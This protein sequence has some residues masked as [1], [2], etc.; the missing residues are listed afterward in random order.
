[1]TE[2]KTA[3]C[4]MHDRGDVRPS[5]ISH[6]CTLHVCI[7]H[8]SYLPAL[9]LFCF[10]PFAAGR[11][12]Q[13]PQI[14]GVRVGFA[15]RYKAGLWTPVEGDAPRRRR[16]A[17]RPRCRSPCPTA[18]AC[19]AA[20]P[21]PPTSLYLPPAGETAVQ[22]FVRFGRVNSSLKIEFR[23]GDEVVARR[24]FETAAQ[25]DDEHF[26]PGCESQKLIVA[27]GPAGIAEPMR[28]AA[29][30][31]R[32]PGER[33]AAV[34]R[35]DDST[36]CPRT[37]TATKASTRWCS[38]PAGRKSTP[39]SSPTTNVA[40]PRRVDAHRRAAGGVRRLEG[41]SGAGESPL[42]AVRPRETRQD[43]PAA[44]DRRLETYCRSSAS[45]FP[46]GR[47]ADRHARAAAEPTCEARSRSAR[48]ICRW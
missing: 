31:Q 24:T 46:A 34:A 48:P 25:A 47:R 11:R 40:G 23:V 15:D 14:A 28:Q 10:S 20:C 27:V 1:M 7:S 33:R 37:G 17:C 18:T 4:E 30:L 35:L 38:R 42:R 29:V 41:R 26:L 44:T 36:R 43:G 21:T 22:L 19:P 12:A 5:C 13:P 9:R 8:S 6:C 16:G 32:L 39:A 2:C 3:K 45:V